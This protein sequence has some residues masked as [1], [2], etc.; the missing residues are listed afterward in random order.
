LFIEMGVPHVIAFDFEHKLYNCSTF[1]DNVYT[2]PKR[3][4][5]IYDYCVGF[6]KHLILES[7]VQDAWKKA[8]PR[9]N[10]GLRKVTT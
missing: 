4:D 3:Y 7:S 1:M 6:Y 10:D 2:L 8:K 9:L 5:Y